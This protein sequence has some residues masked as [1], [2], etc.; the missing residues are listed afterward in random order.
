MYT[1]HPAFQLPPLDT[2][3]WRYTSLAKLVHNL[4]SQSL[5]FA[6]ADKLG[7]PFE[8]SLPVAN[9]IDRR[10]KGETLAPGQRDR[11][12]VNCWHV[13][14]HESYAFWNIYAREHEGLAIRSTI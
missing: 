14:N 8:S 5:F 13:N 11:T 6:R 2:M 4:Q 3:I 7:D 10:R 12:L 1:E 9:A